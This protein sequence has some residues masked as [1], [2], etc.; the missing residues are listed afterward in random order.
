[1]SNKT[2]EWIRE[3]KTSHAANID[4]RDR[5]VL[6]LLSSTFGFSF[7]AISQLEK[8][9]DSLLYKGYFTFGWT[10]LVI[11][12]VLYLVNFGLS[13]KG[14][15]AAI[16]QSDNSKDQPI[17]NFTL[18]CVKWINSIVTVFFLLALISIMLF[19]FFNLN[20]ISTSHPYLNL[21]L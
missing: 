13:N 9:W 15:K 3:Y 16:S 8:N 7:L 11:T 20:P 21:C 10:I 4:A 2:P 17:E 18:R 6:I 19:V 1:M 14:L 12:V 5:A